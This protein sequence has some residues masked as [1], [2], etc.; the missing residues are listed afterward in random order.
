MAVPAGAYLWMLAAACAYGDLIESV[1]DVHRAALYEAAGY[2]I[3]SDHTLEPEAG[4]ALTAYLWHG[5]PPSP[6]LLRPVV[7][8]NS[9]ERRYRPAQPTARRGGADRLR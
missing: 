7:S 9:H 1:F 3:P 5:T 4:R 2:R 6:E 8:S